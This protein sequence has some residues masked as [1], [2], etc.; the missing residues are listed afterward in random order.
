MKKIRF[1]NLTEETKWIMLALFWL[2]LF[3][4]GFVYIIAPWDSRDSSIRVIQS[5]FGGI[6]TDINAFW[7][8]DIG[9]K[10]VSTMMFNAFYPPI[11]FFGFFGLRYLKRVID[12]RKLI[13]NDPS[14]THCKHL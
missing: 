5:F 14:R 2:N 12:Q 3:V 1:K 8:D 11:E 6:Y 4:Y 10:I 9:K 7:F 13:P